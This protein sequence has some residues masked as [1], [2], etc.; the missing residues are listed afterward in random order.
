MKPLLETLKALDELV[1]TRGLA[2]TALLE[3]RTR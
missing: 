3:K 1:K 2:E